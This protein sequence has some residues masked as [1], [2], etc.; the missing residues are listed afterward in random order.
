M[1][2]WCHCRLW[3]DWMH[4]CIRLVVSTYWVDTRLF[5]PFAWWLL[6]T[7][8][9]G[10]QVSLPSRGSWCSCAWQGRAGREFKY[11]YKV[12]LT[13]WM[14]HGWTCSNTKNATNYVLVLFWWHLKQSTYDRYSPRDMA[15]CHIFSSFVISSSTLRSKSRFLRRRYE[16]EVPTSWIGPQGSSIDTYFE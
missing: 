8:R 5:F 7:R 1:L 10:N 4:S 6:F 11:R 12:R 16:Y 15:S 13:R 14:I 3:S 9:M 2:I